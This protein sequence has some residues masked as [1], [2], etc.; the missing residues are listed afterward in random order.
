M[1]LRAAIQAQGLNANLGADSKLAGRL[2]SYA[3]L[4]ASQGC[5]ESALVYLGDTGTNVQLQELKER[6]E[7][8]VAGNSIFFKL[9]NLSFYF[10][11]TV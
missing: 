4:L 3:V 7:K 6:L 2:A 5:L 10:S 8:A 1:M 11:C 9:S